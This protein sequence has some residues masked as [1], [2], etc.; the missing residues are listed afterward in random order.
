MDYIRILGLIAAT[1]TTISFFPQAVK[2]IKTRDAHSISLVMYSILVVGIAM[3][4]VYG[5]LVGD[6]PILL[7]NIITLIPTLVILVIKIRET[8]RK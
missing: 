1:L 6:L 7:A 3:W 8:A 2:I 4:V 5:F